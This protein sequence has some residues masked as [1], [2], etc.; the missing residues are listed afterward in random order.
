MV[1]S[2]SCFGKYGSELE[3]LGIPVKALKISFSP[4][5]IIKFFELKKI[6]QQEK[7]DIVQTWMYHA[8]FLGGLASRLAGIENIIWGIRASFLSPNLS[9]TTTRLLIKI[10]AR[11]SNIVP[12]RI[13]T[14]ALSARRIHKKFGY[15]QEKLITIQNGCDVS[16]FKPRNEL[17][18]KIRYGI[19]IKTTP[20]TIGSVG[21]FD[22]QKDYENLLDALVLLK[23]K[24]IRFQCVLAGTGLDPKNETLKEWII[25]KNLFGSIALLGSQNDIPKIMNAFDVHV[26]S[27]AYGEAFPN[28]VTEAMACGVPCVVTKVGDASSIIGKTGWAVPPKNPEKLAKAIEAA[29]IECKGKRWAKR[30]KSVRSRITSRYCMKKMCNA[31]EHLWKDL[32]KSRKY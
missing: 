24:N 27:S 32:I 13:V 21:R 14:C 23:K 3:A 22:P 5:S 4:T 8:D 26:L 18:S 2:L 17:K 9:K 11:L 6:L 12:K 7:P 25:Q 31:Y 29:F 30:C 10:L 1:I 19:K 16:R 15:S 28:V 20:F